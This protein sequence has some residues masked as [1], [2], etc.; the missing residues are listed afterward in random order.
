MCQFCWLE[1]KK[2]CSWQFTSSKWQQIRSR[3]YRAMN[4]QWV[5]EASCP[6]LAPWWGRLHS[7]AQLGQAPWTA[8]ASL[9]WPQN[10]SLPQVVSAGLV[11]FLTCC[12]RT[13][14]ESTPDVGREAARSSRAALPPAVTRASLLV[15]PTSQSP[16]SDKACSTLLLFCPVTEQSFLLLGAKK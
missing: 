2:G 9:C 14:R 3:G 6:S 7:W 5:Q 11:R 10:R 16:C 4:H 15:H 13:P 12:L 8:A 1:N